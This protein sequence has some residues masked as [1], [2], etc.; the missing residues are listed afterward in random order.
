MGPGRLL[1][2]ELRSCL[3]RVMP[4]LITFYENH[5]KE[6]DRFEIVS[7]CIDT[8]GQIKS[9]ADLDQRLLPIVDHVWEKP[10]PFPI[11][12]DPTFTTWERYGLPGLGTLVLLDPEGNLVK[13]DETV[14]AEKL[15][16]R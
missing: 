12:I 3:S 11:L 13:G 10:L 4:R 7:I 6:R 8:E 15:K 9:I 14:L 16:Q 2:A 1:G 5:A